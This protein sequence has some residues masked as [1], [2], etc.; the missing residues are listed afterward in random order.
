MLYYCKITVSLAD[1]DA[2][3]TGGARS[4]AHPQGDHGGRTQEGRR[5]GPENVSGWGYGS[6]IG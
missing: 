4:T 1:G 3:P 6:T 2:V 5:R